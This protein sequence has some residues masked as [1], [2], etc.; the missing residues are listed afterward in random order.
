MGP[1]RGRRHKC[2]ERGRRP[3]LCAAAL[4]VV[5]LYS[6][7]VA[8]NPHPS[9]TS[10][11]QEPIAIRHHLFISHPE[12]AAPPCRFEYPAPVPTSYEAVVLP[13]KE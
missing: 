3:G 10:V 13:T 2:L 8:P 6:P 11:T 7:S 12:V 4:H 9:F 5:V 1:G